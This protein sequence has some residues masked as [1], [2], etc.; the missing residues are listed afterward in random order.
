MKEK[1]REE[2]YSKCNFKTYFMSHHMKLN[3]N[4]KN[5]TEVV[6]APSLETFKARPGFEQPDLEGGVPAY[7][8]G[9]GTR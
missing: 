8:R 1:K 9:V 2:G 6:D 4:I 5:K 7:S 3:I